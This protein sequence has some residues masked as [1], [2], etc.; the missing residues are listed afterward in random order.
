MAG[1]GSFRLLEPWLRRC[2]W[3]TRRAPV[4]RND[5]AAA[6][7]MDL[8]EPWA[9]ETAALEGGPVPVIG[10]SRGGQEGRVLAVR[11]PE[12]VSLLVTL[13][14][15]HQVLV[16]PHV[17]I[18]LPIA[19]LQVRAWARKAG[20]EPVAQARYEADLRRPFPDTVPFVNIYSRTDGFLDWRSCLD[21]GSEGVEIDCTHLGLT[22][23]VPAFRA[24]ADALGRLELERRA[25]PTATRTATTR[26]CCGATAGAPPR[27]RR[28]TSSPT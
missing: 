7:V 6:V 10:H 18:R 2:G 28:P 5:Q 25:C 24:I 3:E 17:A 4:G 15:P 27:T 23:S 13:G 1:T 16:P 8:I 22:A 9:R 20:P 11:R 21:P 12:D 14:A 19:A 26:A